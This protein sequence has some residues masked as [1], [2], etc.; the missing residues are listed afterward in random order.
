M[1][2]I[3][4]TKGRSSYQDALAATRLDTSAAA[5][6]PAAAAASAAAALS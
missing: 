4:W 2:A 5:L 1:Y 3:A 6:G